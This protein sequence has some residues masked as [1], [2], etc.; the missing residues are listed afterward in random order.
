MKW[1]KKFAEWRR[2]RRGEVTV[3]DNHLA[4]ESSE[5]SLE[6]QARKKLVKEIMPHIQPVYAE[7]AAT[8]LL[9]M[10]MIRPVKAIR[11]PLKL[12]LIHH[13]PGLVMVKPA[14]H[15][16]MAAVLEFDYPGMKIRCACLENGK[17]YLHYRLY[18]DD[19]IRQHEHWMPIDD[20]K[21]NIPS[22][23]LR[24]TK[25]ELERIVPQAP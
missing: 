7:R 25:A 12:P 24:A 17:A 2:T 5:S 11:R 16:V 21:S 22:A 4:I 13:V 1:C 19:G 9:E 23:I 10:K 14:K 15:E 6:Y 18:G 8:H 3:K 20:L